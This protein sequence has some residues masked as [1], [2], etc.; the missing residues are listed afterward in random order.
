MISVSHRR[1]ALSGPGKFVKSSVAMRLNSDFT[2]DWRPTLG[3]SISGKGR[4][5]ET[6]EYYLNE[7][8]ALL[9]CMFSRTDQAAA[10]RKQIVEVFIAH[11]HGRLVPGKSGQG[12]VGEEVRTARIGHLDRQIALLTAE[13]K[14]E[15]AAAPLIRGNLGS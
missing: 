10:V 4:V 2:E 6:V 12:L 7:A 14:K 8:Q 9:V 3:A 5:A 11:R 1:L 15:A 13:R